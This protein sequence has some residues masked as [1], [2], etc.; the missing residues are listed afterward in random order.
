MSRAI[1]GPG[2]D[3]L[4]DEELG[5]ALAWL[6][7]HP[8][9]FTL[10]GSQRMVW[11]WKAGRGVASRED[12]ESS[13]SSWRDMAA[14]RGKV[15]LHVV[16]KTWFDSFI[17]PQSWAGHDIFEPQWLVDTLRAAPGVG[18]VSFDASAVMRAWDWPLDVGVFGENVA[19]L[20][21]A[22]DGSFPTEFVAVHDAL[23]APTKLDL[24]LFP[25]TLSDLFAEVLRGLSLPEVHTVLALGG[26]GGARGP[27]PMLHALRAETEAAVVGA[28][29]IEREDVEGWFHALVRELSH[30]A[31]LDTALFRVRRDLPTPLL[32]G[33]VESFAAARGSVVARRLGAR[34]ARK[35]SAVKPR[36]PIDNAERVLGLADADL[37]ALGAALLRRNTDGSAEWDHE[38]QSASAV[39]ELRRAEREDL[40]S[41]A[42]RFLQGRVRRAGSDE[43]LGP[44]PLSRETPYELD[45]AIAA[46]REGWGV[47][48]AAFADDALP[49]APDGHSLTVVFA[50]PEV[51]PEPAVRS[52]WLPRDGDSETVSFPFTLPAT[53]SSLDAR[54]TVLYRGRI[55]QTLKLRAGITGTDGARPLSVALEAVV[56]ADLAGI[57]GRPAFHTALLFND[58][59][60]VPGVTGFSAGRAV[61][62][63]LDDL[64]RKVTDL[65]NKLEV[66]CTSPGD[67]AATDAPNTQQ[68]LRALASVGHA[69]ANDLRELP[70][71]DAVL[72]G[73]SVQTARIQLLSMHMD[74]LVPI[75]YAYDGPF[76]ANDAELCEGWREAL[77]AGGKGHACAESPKK[78]CP[79]RF[80][81][82]R[83][84]IERA[85]Y[86]PSDAA[87]IQAANGDYEVRCEARSERTPLTV[88]GVLLG[89]A[90]RAQDY[91]PAAFG[92]GL[93]R[94]EDALQ[95]AGIGFYRADDWE[96]WKQAVRTSTPCPDVLVLIT[97]TSATE[98]GLT[99]ELGASTLYTEQL[100]N[101]HVRVPK[102]QPPAPGPVVL[103]LGCR[104]A[105]REMPFGDA[106]KAFRRKRASVILA[107][108]T[109]VR[110]RH[111]IGVAEGVVRKLLTRARAAPSRV[112]EFVVEL[113][114]ELLACDLPVGLALL[115]YGDIDWQIGEA[116]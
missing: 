76:P 25:G 18:A 63:K 9:W 97:H 114:R 12:L 61:Y 7:T 11:A 103:V 13:A 28:L 108:L 35:K 56:S 49:D 74:K 26:V 5:A 39:A 54:V 80:W 115:S 73:P 94:I 58:T 83:H 48:P 42:R 10:V 101:D 89:R 113:R 109:D 68:L 93:A 81:G 98:Q 79:L 69:F 46:P 65:Q 77:G 38:Y 78:I 6:G 70:G 62:F 33:N 3:G 51:L 64:Q 47:A 96:A 59:G 71:M 15:E 75:E 44:E 50:A 53:A 95:T 90:D 55:L 104:S 52:L 107:M 32:V 92:A 72:P 31:P 23:F 20:R 41:V 36:G 14:E 66:I 106:I 22:L 1:I 43:A 37:Q 8:A 110:G 87:R 30:D 57:D 40:D 16:R 60:G 19:A 2:A 91:D 21:T 67:Y 24:V 116:S 86:D 85:L 100:G 29:S 99:L 88:R 27:V 45:V 4:S 105:T 102:P 84:T 112:G 34:L 111:M 17:D 82:M